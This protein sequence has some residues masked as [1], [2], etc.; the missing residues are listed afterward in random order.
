M[1]TRIADNVN[2]NPTLSSNNKRNPIVFLEHLNLNIGTKWTDELESFFF[3]ILGCMFDSRSSQILQNNQRVGMQSNT[4]MK[5]ANVGYQ[6]FHLVGY[7]KENCFDHLKA[8]NL[9]IPSTWSCRQKIYGIIGLEF[10]ISSNYEEQQ[11]WEELQRRLEQGLKDGVIDHYEEVKV[12]L[13]PTCVEDVDADNCVHREQL[14]FRIVAC[15]GNTFQITAQ[16]PASSVGTDDN[17]EYSPY[18]IGPTWPPPLVKEIPFPLPTNDPSG[19]TTIGEGIGHIV[20]LRSV[21]YYVPHCNRR[22]GPPVLE[23]GDTSSPRQERTPL[24]VIQDAYNSLFP[25]IVCCRGYSKTVSKTSSTSSSSAYRPV[26]E[27]DQRKREYLEIRIGHERNPQ[28]LRFTLLHPQQEE[29][30]E[31]SPPYDGHHVAIYIHDFAESYQRAKDQSLIFE[32]SIFP[33]FSYENLKD[34]LEFQEFRFCNFVDTST[35][36]TVF[37]LEHEVRSLQHQGFARNKHIWQNNNSS[38]RSNHT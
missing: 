25:G 30:T 31:E 28:Y 11:C 13:L 33:Q 17:H 14:A 27:Q 38:S 32:N 7:D 4:I 29:E 36:I 20:G 22:L 19:Y 9:L 8:Q 35:N 34:A 15:H 26:S 5:W 21:E 23:N 10:G 16:Q 12:L 18:Y 24:D 1:S 37:N 6:Q 2:A 3:K